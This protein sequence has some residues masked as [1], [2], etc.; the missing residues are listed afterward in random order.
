MLSNVVL[1]YGY[2]PVVGAA[3]PT[4]VFFGMAIFALKRVR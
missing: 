1:L 3:L 4:A 2:P